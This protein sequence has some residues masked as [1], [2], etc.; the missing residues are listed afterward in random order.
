MR[1][2]RHSA[3]LR[4]LVRPWQAQAACPASRDR[5]D[6]SC[7]DGEETC[8][9]AP[10]RF[11]QPAGMTLRHPPAGLPPQPQQL[12]VHR[13]PRISN[14]CVCACA[15]AHLAWYFGGAEQRQAREPCPNASLPPRRG[16]CHDAS[17]CHVLRISPHDAMPPTPRLPAAF[18]RYRGPSLLCPSRRAIPQ[19]GCRWRLIVSLATG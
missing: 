3:T 9:P 5:R 12:A 2:P 1:H 18:R 8:R 16:A 6:F 19:K 14:A 4:R 10:T 13:R 15:P 7:V 11:L 17:P